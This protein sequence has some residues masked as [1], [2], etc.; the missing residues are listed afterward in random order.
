MQTAPTPD[1][2]VRVRGRLWTVDHVTRHEDCAAL[3]LRPAGAEAARPADPAPVTLLAP[4]DRPVRLAAR[5]SPLVVSRRRWM[6]ACRAAL[7]RSGDR[8]SL[9]AAARADLVLM[10]YQLEPAIETIR[11]GSPRILLA[12]AVGLGKTIQAG[13]ITAELV[14][15]RALERALILTP[16]GL[17]DQWADELLARFGLAST[18]ADAAWLRAMRAEWPASLNPWSI[19][20]VLIA[21]VDFVKRPEVRRSLGDLSW[22]LV[23]VDEAHAACGDSDRRDAAHWCA[24][25]AR[26]VLL[27]TATPHAGDDAAFDALARIGSLGDDD[28]I[29]LFRRSRADVGLASLRRVRLLRVRGTMTE[30]S[31]HRALREYVRAVWTRAGATQ[32]EGARLAMV[33][34]V[35]RSLSGMAPLVRS[36]EARHDALAGT[37]PSCEH[38]LGLPWEDA[39]DDADTLPAGVLGAPGSM[40]STASASG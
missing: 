20:G 29:A 31:V 37:P 15:R 16:P 5:S 27:L 34:L 12:D 21:S 6:A 7:G 3:H 10:P 2:L 39:L 22:D 17:R 13:I 8:T 23:I 25:R 30:A 24:S 26:R 9:H 38:Q 4:F 19:P 33:V 18:V 11:N 32:R 40:T 28:P 36:L 35:K 14:R 1:E